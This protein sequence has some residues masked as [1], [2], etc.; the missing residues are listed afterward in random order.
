M[1]AYTDLIRTL[2]HLNPVG[3]EASMRLQY[4]TLD[5]LSRDDFK[6]E[7]ALALACE[8]AEPG[9]LR[10]CAD[11]FGMLA[12]FDRFEMTRPFADADSAYGWS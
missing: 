11:S 5:H 10:K 9:Y 12:E 6:Q 1:S 2:T 3:V 4:S 8:M 7:A